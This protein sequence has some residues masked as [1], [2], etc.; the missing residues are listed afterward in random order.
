MVAIKVGT[1]AIYEKY[2]DEC[3]SLRIVLSVL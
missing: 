2:V 1:T 3:K